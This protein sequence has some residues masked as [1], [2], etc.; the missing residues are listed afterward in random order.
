MKEEKKTKEN[1]E[2]TEDEGR[3]RKAGKGRPM[4]EGR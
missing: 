1:A 2:R 3:W 4:K